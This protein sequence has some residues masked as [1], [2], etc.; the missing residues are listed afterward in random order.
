S[1]LEV[2]NLHVRL[3]TSSGVVKAVDGVSFEIRAGKTLGIV[4]ESG[5]GKSVLAQSLM[6]LNPSPPAYYP[7]GE[8]LYQGDDLL[9]EREQK[10]QWIR[11]ND[12]VMVFQELLTR[13][14]RVYNMV[15]S[16]IYS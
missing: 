8:I 2:K 4:G 10:I 7:K 11:G 12:I 13:P 15:D 5:S 16:C 9:K 1:V 14:N 3:D 6:Q